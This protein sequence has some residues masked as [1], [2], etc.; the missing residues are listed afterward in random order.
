M[1]ETN[2]KQF[3]SE[4][5]L[6][7]EQLLEQLRAAGVSKS[8]SEDALSEQD[9]TALRNH[10][11]VAHGGTVDNRI[12]LQRKETSEIRKS[13]S[14]GKSRTI[15]VE[16]RKKRV[17]VLP[18]ALV[19]A[20]PAPVAAPAAESIAVTEPTPTP[21]VTPEPVAAVTPAE[22]TPVVA[23]EPVVVAVAEAPVVAAAPAAPR[24]RT[25]HAVR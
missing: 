19:A 11:R 18:D 23:A 1:L 25:R 21:V 4:L 9:K 8:S 24:F 2:V 22:T 10:L 5:N 20:Q 12:T 17:V 7:P 3:A 15:Q 16:V 14:T 13:D 6:Q